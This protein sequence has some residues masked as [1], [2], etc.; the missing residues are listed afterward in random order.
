MR[1]YRHGQIADPGGASSLGAELVGAC[2]ALP[3]L[4]D[5]ALA[6]F[7]FRAATGAIWSVVQAQ[8][9]RRDIV[10]LEPARRQGQGDHAATARLDELLGVL[11]GACRVLAT[12][13]EPFLPAGSAALGRQFG[14]GG[15][16]AAPLAPV[17]PRLSTPE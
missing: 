16:V 9:A 13:L 3:H 15:G 2:Q 17:F 11:A 14:T 12:E 10:P 7:D 8:P 5:D 4:I 6:R 1:R